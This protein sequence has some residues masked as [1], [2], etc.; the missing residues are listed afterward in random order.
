MVAITQLIELE[1]MLNISDT[2][3]EAMDCCSEVGNR[4]L[5][6]QRKDSELNEAT[7]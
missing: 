6:Q 3:Q 7:R 4:L 5:L 1:V 2:S